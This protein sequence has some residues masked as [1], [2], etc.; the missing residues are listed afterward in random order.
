MLGSDKEK[1]LRNGCI[2]RYL[3]NQMVIFVTTSLKTSCLH[4]RIIVIDSPWQL[5]SDWLQLTYYYFHNI[6]NLKHS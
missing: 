2:R 4:Q 6:N 1:H 3:Y 5:T